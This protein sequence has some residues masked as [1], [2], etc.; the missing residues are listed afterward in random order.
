[1]AERNSIVNFYFN[2]K[3]ILQINPSHPLIKDL[4]HRLETSSKDLELQTQVYVI[5]Q[6]KRIRFVF[7]S[8][9]ILEFRKDYV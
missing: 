1:M 4:L 8:F 9:S 2:Q 7:T 6:M 5:E 3:K